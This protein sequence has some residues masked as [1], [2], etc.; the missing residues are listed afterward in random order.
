MQMDPTKHKRLC[1]ALPFEAPVKRG[2]QRP[3]QGKSFEAIALSVVAS[4]LTAQV[5]ATFSQ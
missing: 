4:R 5:K 2:A 3:G 1:H